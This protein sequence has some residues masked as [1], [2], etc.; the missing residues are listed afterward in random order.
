MRPSSK[1]PSRRPGPRA[2]RR[3]PSP[4]R[5]D[6][7]AFS[8]GLDEAAEHFRAGRLDAAA[9]LY[10][11]LEHQAPDD[12]RPAYSL[13]VIDIRQGRLDR[14][15]G[16]LETVVALDPGLTAAQHNLGAVRQ[17][18]GDWGGAAEAYERALALN[19]EAAE[20][21]AGLAAALTALGQGEAAIGHQRVLAQL[22]AMRWAALTRVA[23]IDPAAITDGELAEMQDAARD[24]RVDATARTGLLFALGDVL[25]ARGEPTRAFAAYAEGNR[26][27]HAALAGA[28]SP[29]GVAQ[30]NAAAA[31]YV[32]QLVDGDF[33]AER[34][35]QGVRSAAPIFIVGFPR[36]GSTLV[37]QIL[38]SHPQVQGLGET[39]VLP[40]LVAR[41]YPT[42]RAGMRD[43][44]AAYLAG[45]RER[46]WDGAS[47]FVD[48]TLEN[49]LHVGL[50]HVL[51]PRATILHTVRDP[52]DT[53][54]ACYRQLF[55][56][57]N[58]TLYDLADIGA[59]YARYRELM[60]HWEAVL[61]GRVT[62][63]GYE[64]LVANPP[65]RIRSLV[66][67]AA[68]LP[69]DAATLAF[70]ERA[71][72]VGTASAS[73]VRKPI[74]SASVQR[75]RRHAQALQ[76]LIAALG[77]YGPGSSGI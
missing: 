14:A 3:K 47:R 4:A 23:L 60:A 36:S 29:A 34:A 56:R 46:G 42:G 9:R 12:V 27:K 58:E 68:R 21:R 18:L 1:E 37:E 30:A 69:W 44:A 31:R 77:P 53:G 13:A 63:V 73:Q 67:E 28:A 65:A 71:G 54:F 57:G 25:E 76:P 2:G 6:P 33:L 10:G 16:R 26:L 20:T 49:Y 72:G 17:Q 64:A 55:V 40:A 48:K 15:R 66:T 5:A 19:P 50:I 8:R 70:H 43:L 38:A 35:G 11:R 61:P 7:A 62:E 52:V 41:G 39:G 32:R 74:Y 59:E 22:P 24:H 51:F 45:L 75:W